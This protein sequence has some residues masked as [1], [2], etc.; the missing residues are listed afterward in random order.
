[1]SLLAFLAAAVVPAVTPG[2]GI[3]YAVART[4]AVG[5]SEG[6]ASFLGIGVGRIAPVLAAALALARR[7]G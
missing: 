7:E 1:M 6:L 3:A 5:R 4:A 2:L